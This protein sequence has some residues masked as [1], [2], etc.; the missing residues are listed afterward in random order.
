MRWD[1]GF[2]VEEEAGAQG[3]PTEASPPSPQGSGV[4]CGVGRRGATTLF[5]NKILSSQAQEWT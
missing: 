3:A 2:P 4:G 1:K 5:G